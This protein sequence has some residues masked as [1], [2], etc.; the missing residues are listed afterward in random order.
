MG[1]SAGNKLPGRGVDMA[2]ARL[3]LQMIVEGYGIA[4]ITEKLGFS[5][6]SVCRR[7]IQNA[8][9]EQRELGFTKEEQRII[10]AESIRVRRHHLH[11]IIGRTHYSVSA[12][13]KVA[14][15]PQTGLPLVDDGPAQRAITELRHLDEQFGEYVNLKPPSKRSIE[16][17]PQDVVDREIK[18]LTQ[19]IAAR[20]GE[21]PQN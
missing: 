17:I 16:V 14:A 1:R 11:K 2:R 12:S 8:M 3:G 7:S 20:G 6:T 4:E 9:I 21:V 18:K 19:E 13:G 5:A 10:L 15:D